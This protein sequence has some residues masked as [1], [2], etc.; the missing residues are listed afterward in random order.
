MEERD[1]P[2]WVKD[3]IIKEKLFWEE[4]YPAFSFEDKARYWSGTLL[5]QMRWQGESGLDQF[6][7]YTPEWYESV[8]EIE[9]DFDKIMDEVFDKY[10]KGYWHD[11]SWNKYKYYQR[12]GK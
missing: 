9:P 8:K 12:I 1:L 3:T 7:F 6:Y 4:K 11:D 5:R 2:K 10:W